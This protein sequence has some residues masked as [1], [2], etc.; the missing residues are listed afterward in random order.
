MLKKNI[1][2][3]I[4][5]L[6]FIS[7]T[8]CSKNENSEIGITGN[9]VDE[10][11]KPLN[12]V[13]ILYSKSLISTQTDFLGNFTI[14]QPRT[15]FITFKKVGYRTLT[16]Q[17]NNFSENAP[18]NFNTITLKKTSKP[19]ANYKDISLETNAK[20]KNLKV[21]GNI[22]N[23]FREPLKDVNIEIN[24]TSTESYNFDNTDYNGRFN[25][26]LFYNQISIKKVGFRK[27]LLNLPVYDKDNQKI[28]LL[29]KTTK[30]GIYLIKFGKYIPLPKTKLTYK[31]QKKMGHILWGG[32]FG[33]DIT[34]FYYPKKAK[35]FKIE[36]D[37]L[38]RFIIY[39]ASFSSNLFEARK[40]DGYLCTADY[41]YT[42]SPFPATKKE[43]D[44]IKVAY[45][46]KYCTS[47]SDEP[48]IIDFKP[49]NKNKNYV[50][51]NTENKKGYYFTY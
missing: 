19:S 1:I 50:F 42:T 27:I 28:T 33:Y 46:S 36:N 25:F 21:S 24:D 37:T 41:K 30:T 26:R 10:L 11:G 29:Q 13:S 16:T 6:G 31:S 2:K 5:L 38:L 34:D 3:L 23:V 20:F 4:I 51:V 35:E 7:F 40:N 15:L 47:S 48:K 43:L 14:N 45:P 9:I 8:G 32:N 22:S 17:I 39:E 44:Y 12:D 49:L 18:Y